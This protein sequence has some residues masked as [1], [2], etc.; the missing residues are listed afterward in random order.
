MSALK[1]EFNCSDGLSQLMPHGWLLKL[2]SGCQ[3][4]KGS[5]EEDSPEF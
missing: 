1:S 2:Q 5:P 3:I 4:A